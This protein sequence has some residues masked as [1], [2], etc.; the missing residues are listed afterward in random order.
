GGGVHEQAREAHGAVSSDQGAARRRRYR[1]VGDG[2]AGRA[3]EAS[4]F[5]PGTPGEDPREDA[6]VS[7]AARSP[8]GLK[9]FTV[10]VIDDDALILSTLAELLRAHGHRI[11]EAPTG[12]VGIEVARAERPDL[13][14]MDHHMPEMDGLAVVRALY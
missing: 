6:G 5:A 1:R 3:H 4:A 9:Q 2:A 14:L 11:L 13:I 12:R 7:A 8:H 10:L